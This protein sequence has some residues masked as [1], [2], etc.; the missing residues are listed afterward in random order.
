MHPHPRFGKR[1]I[2]ADSSSLTRRVSSISP[3]IVAVRSAEGMRVDPEG[4]GA[5][6]R[7]IP[8]ARGSRDCGADDHCAALY[9]ARCVRADRRSSRG[10]QERRVD[11]RDPRAK[12]HRH[13]EEP[14]ASQRS[15]GFLQWCHTLPL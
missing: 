11:R 13:A 7:I 15:N 10:S 6:E 12:I 5:I 14:S 3:G 4:E 2:R 8:W 9:G 1:S